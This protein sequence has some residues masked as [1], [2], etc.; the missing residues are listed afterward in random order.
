MSGTIVYKIIHEFLC[1]F[2]S[3]IYEY[4]SF[5]ICLG[6]LNYSIREDI[7]KKKCVTECISTTC[8]I[9]QIILKTTFYDV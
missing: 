1:S 7:L 8:K 4:I 3:I 5:V 2:S 6:K 9:I